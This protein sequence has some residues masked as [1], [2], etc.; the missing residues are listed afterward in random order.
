[1]QT[2]VR[3]FGVCGR[4]RRVVAVLLASWALAPAGP[5]AERPAAAEPA[6]RHTIADLGL[7]LLRVEPGTFLMGSPDDEP[8]RNKVEGPQRRV[9]LTQPFWLGRTEVTQAQY[10][11][12]VG[13]NP[14]TF[15]ANGG[16]APVE[17]VSW[18]E[19]MAFCRRLTARE[20]A[21]GRLSQDYEYTLPTEAQWEYACRAGHAGAYAGEPDALGW[22]ATNSG[23]T[24]HA[25]GGKRPNAWGFHDMSGNVLEWCRDWY[26]PYPRGAAIDPSGPAHGY[27]RVARG[28]S[29]RT[30]VETGR[31]AARG[32]GSAGRQ[33]YTLGFRLALGRVPV[34][35]E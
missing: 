10:A 3:S 23:G 28:G 32:G 27:Y 22:F 17:R 4:L 8:G 18:L 9:T 14:S 31:S 15:Q 11:A 7:D 5:G 13:V 16:D 20:R 33:D 26:G 12:V 30:A 21:A 2:P 35:R 19:A 6:A 29:W 24:T 34:A 1:M 25:V